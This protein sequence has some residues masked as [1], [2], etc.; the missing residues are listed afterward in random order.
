MSRRTQQFFSNTAFSSW[1]L[2]NSSACR[3][4]ITN[5][6]SQGTRRQRVDG[7]SATP[8]HSMHAGGAALPAG[9]KPNMPSQRYPA[10][11]HP[12][13]AH[14]WLLLRHRSCGIFSTS[15]CAGSSRLSSAS[16]LGAQASTRDAGSAMTCRYV[17]PAGHS[18]IS[19]SA[20]RPQASGGQAGGGSERVDQAGGWRHRMIAKQQRRQRVY[21]GTAA[22]PAAAHLT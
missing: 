18:G 22:A 10:V 1:S 14:H 4:F 20:G 8:G 15:A 13:T 9:L 2:V 12:T 17:S 21:A 16:S 19:L 7:S 3:R 11:R 5:L 6:R